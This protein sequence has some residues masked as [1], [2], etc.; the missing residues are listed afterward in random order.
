MRG[1]VDSSLSRHVEEFFDAKSAPHEDTRLQVPWVLLE[2]A[3]ERIRSHFHN[4]CA[5]LVFTLDEVLISEWELKQISVAV[6]I[7]AGGDHM[8]RFLVSSHVSNSIFKT[9]KSEGVRI[10]SDIILR[11]R[12]K[13]YMNPG[14]FAECLLMVLLLHIPRIR[15]DP[16]FTSK[17]VGLLMDNCSLHMRE[18]ILQTLADHCLKVF[19]VSWKRELRLPLDNDDSAAVLI[20]CLCPHWYSI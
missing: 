4:P 11:G 20:K 6:C 9:L 19:S 8:T 15:S 5:E 10:G 16:K 18:D 3:V 1:W 7:S 14:L 2:A 13:P 17:E 12:D